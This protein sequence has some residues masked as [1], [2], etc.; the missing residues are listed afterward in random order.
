MGS[1]SPIT[2]PAGLRPGTNVCGPHELLIAK[3]C[4]WSPE[5]IYAL[6]VRGLGPRY[7]NKSSRFCASVGVDGT[8]VDGPVVCRTPS[9]EGRRATD[10]ERQLGYR[11]HGMS[12][13][14][15][16]SIRYK[17]GG[18]NRNNRIKAEVTNRMK[19]RA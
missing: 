13:F 7:C 15:W 12:G 17:V 3:L 19:P 14:V 11:A 8:V 5:L 16:M 9:A 4:L 1:G 2:S 10:G 18:R 6:R